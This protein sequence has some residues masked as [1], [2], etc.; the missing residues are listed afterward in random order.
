MTTTLENMM[1]E[2]SI[3]TNVISRA[4]MVAFIDHKICGASDEDE[5]SWDCNDCIDRGHLEID[6]GFDMDEPFEGCF[7]I[8]AKFTAE[9]KVYWQPQ[10]YYQPEEV[11]Y[12]DFKVECF[13]LDGE[14]PKDGLYDENGKEY[15][16]DEIYDI[17]A[18]LC[19]QY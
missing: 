8:T 19:K 15:T 14:L 5:F 7:F 12:A 16:L 10:T 3:S 13:D 17:V 4:D 9:H 1:A 6:F 18:E 11:E 2:K